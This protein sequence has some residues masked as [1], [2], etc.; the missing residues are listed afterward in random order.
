[1]ICLPSRRISQRSDARSRRRLG[2]RLRPR[3]RSL[4]LT[5]QRHVLSTLAIGCDRCVMRTDR[6]IA[7]RAAGCNNRERRGKGCDR[8]ID[9]VERGGV[10]LLWSQLPTSP[11][12]PVLTAYNSPVAL[13]SL[14]SVNPSPMKPPSLVGVDEAKILADRSPGREP[15][16]AGRRQLRPV[17][18]T[19]II[20]R[21]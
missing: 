19:E 11:T 3:V 15:T 4:P 21:L 10:V 1:M 13:I 16:N 9:G 6:D 17:L 5:S 14:L 12:L 18:A 20:S 8:G 2:K 7:L